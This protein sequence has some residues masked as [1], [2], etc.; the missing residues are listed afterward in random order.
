MIRSGPLS[1][2]GFV[3]LLTNAPGGLL[4]DWTRRRRLLLASASLMVGCCFGSCRWVCGSR[5]AVFML[6][7]VAGLAQPLFGPLTN[8][9]TLFLVGHSD[10][11]RALGIKEGWNHA[12][13][14]A[15][16]VLAML[17]VGYFSVVAVFL[18]IGVVSVFAAAS[19]LLI[20]PSELNGNRG[21]TSTKRDEARCGFVDVLRDPNVLILLA[22][23]VLFHFA[24]APV[25]PLVA[26]KI[27]HVGGTNSQ[28]AGVVLMAQAVMI[29][30]ALL[31]GLLGDRWGRKPV[32]GIGFAVLPVRHLPVR[33][34]RRP[35]PA[36]RLQA[37][38]GIGAGIFGVTAVAVCGDLTRGR[39]HFNG[40][41]GVLATAIGTGGAVGTLVS[42]L[43]VQILAS[44]PRSS[45]SVESQWQGLCCSSAGC[46]RSEVQGPKI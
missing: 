21:T 43:I 4:I 3:S 38:D 40:L 7:A 10:L 42:G 36:R 17:L 28:V 30:V 11:N 34:H 23:S 5:V 39:G 20:Q 6:L 18:M 1:P 8:A 2:A 26:Q 35:R 44:P 14:I 33:L 16:A 25:M 31:A 15:A 12:G 41:A 32:L 19:G 13:N 27:R 46:P 9:F 45:R 24:N 29:P 22:S 37:L